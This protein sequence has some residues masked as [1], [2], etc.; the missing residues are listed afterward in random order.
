MTSSVFGGIAARNFGYAK[1]EIKQSIARKNG[2]CEVCI[3]T[4][5]QMAEGKP[6]L[7]YR[8]D[9]NPEEK[10]EMAAR[11]ILDVMCGARSAAT[12]ILFFPR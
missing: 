6:G 2:G 8:R 7:E 12:A 3:H 9:D 10:L 5:A 4:D 1:I 11:T